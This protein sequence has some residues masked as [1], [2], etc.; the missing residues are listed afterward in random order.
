[1]FSFPLFTK[2]TEE[3][4][5]TSK[6]ADAKKTRDELISIIK[7]CDQMD[8]DAKKRYELA[9]ANND[10]TRKHY[11][12]LKNEIDEYIK[13]QEEMLK[14]KPTGFELFKRTF[15]KKYGD[16]PYFKSFEEWYNNVSKIKNLSLDI[17]VDD[18]KQFSLLVEATN[19]S[20]TE[21]SQ[22]KLLKDLFNHINK[23]L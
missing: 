11:I 16:E 12:E 3:E 6:L 5:L 9:I 18:K 2:P 13:K 14:H 21:R 4:I 20:D 22:I 10:A 23:L 7:E 8:K 19:L 1:M 15:I 17:V